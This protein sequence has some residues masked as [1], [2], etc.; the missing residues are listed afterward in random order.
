M[1]NSKAILAQA[2][3]LKQLGC[4]V[5]FLFIQEIGFGDGQLEK[6]E[7]NL[8]QTKEYW[9]NHFLYLRIGKVEKFI[10]NLISLFRQKFCGGHEGTY[11]K[12]PWELTSY[13]KKIQRERCYDICLVQYYYLTK[14]FKTVRFEKMACFTHDVF[15]YKNLIVN[16]KCA[17]IDANQE[18]KAVQLCTDV[19]AIQ[20]EEKNYY[21]TLSPQ[22]K[23]YNVY[24]P[25]IFIE[26]PFVRNH[27]I[28]FLSGNNGFNQ[29]GLRWFIDEI[30]PLIRRKYEDANLIIAGGICKVIK[31]QY[32]HIDGIELLGYVE[33]PIEL[34]KLGDVAINPTY[35]GTGLKIKTF[36]AISYGKATMVH[37]HSMAGV[38]NKEMAPL[39]SSDKPQEWLGFIETI[40]GQPEIIRKIKKQDELYIQSMNEYIVQEYKYFLSV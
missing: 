20:E 38:Y 17:W 1:G 23:T 29:N 36:E 6:A 3:I 31:K 2:E 16:E 8:R 32:E 33:D 13:V 10:K 26:T 11:D 37:P 34:Y 21:H 25:Y 15:A 4:D 40:W 18:A 28:V 35:Q 19:L 27:N 14:L 30:F 22:S 24:S 7:R 5:D 39:F 12:Y 9:G